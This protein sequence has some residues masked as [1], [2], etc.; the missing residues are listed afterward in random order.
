M[1]AS[2]LRD[3]GSSYRVTAYED[4][5]AVASTAKYQLTSFGKVSEGSAVFS[6][7]S[8]SRQGKF[9]R[10]VRDKCSLGAPGVLLLQHQKLGMP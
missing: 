3:E 10:H 1:V 6:F 4:K 8:P 5:L 2:S 7:L 9:I